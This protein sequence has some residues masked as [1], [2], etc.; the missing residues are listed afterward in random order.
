MCLTT[1]ES[2]RRINEAILSSHSTVSAA[3]LISY[4]LLTL[5]QALSDA[6]SRLVVLTPVVAAAIRAPAPAPAAQH[7]SKTALYTT[8]SLTT[9]LA[10]PAASPL[11]PVGRLSFGEVGVLL[12]ALLLWH[13]LCRWVVAGLLNCASRPDIRWM[14]FSKCSDLAGN[15]LHHFIKFWLYIWFRLRDRGAE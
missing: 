6:P 13:L 15:A 8:C 1:P 9:T 7:L 12:I 3:L 10:M 5:A 11:L 14:V 4:H 2:C